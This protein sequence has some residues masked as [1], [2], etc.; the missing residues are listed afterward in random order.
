MRADKERRQH[1]RWRGRP[2]GS[3]PRRS[4]CRGGAAKRAPREA[5]DP[6]W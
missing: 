1:I 4:K 6:G 5:A 3:G 2:A